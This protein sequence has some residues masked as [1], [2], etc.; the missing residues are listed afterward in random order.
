VLKLAADLRGRY[1]Q[2]ALAPTDVDAIVGRVRLAC[3]RQKRRYAPRADVDAIVAASVNVPFGRAIDAE[4]LAGGIRRNR[5]PTGYAG[6]FE[7]FLGELPIAEV[8]RFADRHGI[9]APLLARFVRHYREQLGL[10]R[11]ELED[12][13]N[14]L[15]PAS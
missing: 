11:P 8:L 6:H 7:R 4:T 12:H 5:V 1:R 3:A 13:L 2:R 9:N 15:V 14:A 10:R